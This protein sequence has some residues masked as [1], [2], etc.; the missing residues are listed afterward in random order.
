MRG[1]KRINLPPP[2]D[3]KREGLIQ[4]RA[5]LWRRIIENYKNKFCMG[6]GKHKQR[7]TMD[8]KLLVGIEKLKKRARRKSEIITVSDKGNDLVIESIDIYEKQVEEQTGK[9]EKIFRTEISHR[10]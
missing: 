9:D 10:E 8:P 4:T 6:K 7:Q 5:S 1:N 2:L 3:T